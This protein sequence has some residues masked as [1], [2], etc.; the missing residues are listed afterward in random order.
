[1]KSWQA[2]SKTQ[3]PHEI[4]SNPKTKNKGRKSHII[5]HLIFI[6]MKKQKIYVSLNE[7]PEAAA[8]ETA[9]QTVEN[10]I[11]TETQNNETANEA[12]TVTAPEAETTPTA[13][14]EHTT[15]AD[16]TQT[17]IPQPQKKRKRLKSCKNA[18]MLNLP[19]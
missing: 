15:Q 9:A 8:V 3:K 7:T 12:E 17:T 5:N 13:A 1:M 18:L 16:T 10:V 6:F 2:G 19:D 11:P 14:A 4:K